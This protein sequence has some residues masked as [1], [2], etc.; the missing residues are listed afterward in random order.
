MQRTG[1]HLHFEFAA[2]FVLYCVI[3]ALLLIFC[4]SRQSTALLG[5]AENGHTAACE[6][7]IANNAD[8]NAQTMC[9]FNYEIATDSVLY[10]VF[11]LC[12]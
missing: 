1:A 2:D 7:L 11:Q 3:S 9:A 5:A 12:F 6:Q 10:F 4:S 8:V